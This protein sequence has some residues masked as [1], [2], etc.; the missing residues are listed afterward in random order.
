MLGLGRG[1][2][3][4]TGASPELRVGRAAGRAVQGL[5]PPFPLSEA[6]W[7]RWSDGSLQALGNNPLV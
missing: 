3:G 6:H 1:I 2:E 5:K 4:E 7:R